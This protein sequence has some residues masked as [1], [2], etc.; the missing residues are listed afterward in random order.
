MYFA[1]ALALRSAPWRE[2][3]SDEQC[4]EAERAAQRVT[5][6]RYR[7]RLDDSTSLDALRV[8]ADDALSLLMRECNALLPIG[9]DDEH[10]VSAS[11]VAAVRRALHEAE[12]G[13]ALY[14]RGVDVAQ[15]RSL[16]EFERATGIELR[17][18]RV[19]P[20]HQTLDIDRALLADTAVDELA[21]LLA[22]Q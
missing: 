15:R 1:M 19:A 11:S 13:G 22:A 4:G 3:R 6:A 14:A 2:Q 21:R 7:A 12:F 8:A 20:R 10:D 16:D 18:G 9:D 17:V 5:A